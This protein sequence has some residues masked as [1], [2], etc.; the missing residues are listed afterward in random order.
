MATKTGKSDKEHKLQTEEVRLA[1]ED[2]VSDWKEETLAKYRKEFA[3]R[4]GKDEE[5][6]ILTATELSRLGTK[7]A[8][9]VKTVYKK[10]VL[11]RDGK[12]KSYFVA[13]VKRATIAFGVSTQARLAENPG[14]T[15]SR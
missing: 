8:N 11:H 13:P 6:L 2:L 15:V 3:G 12:R 14:K 5:I 9:K 4:L 7:T 10:I 1:V